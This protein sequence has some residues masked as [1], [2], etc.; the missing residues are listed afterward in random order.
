[1]SLLDIPSKIFLEHFVGTVNEGV[2]LCQQEKD[3]TGEEK[4]EKC[5]QF[6]KD[7]YNT[8]DIVL[9]IPSFIDD[10]VL[11]LAPILIDQA[12]RLFNEKGWE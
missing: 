2:Q 6:I 3:L 11:N 12:V 4:K 9:D 8:V 10:L 1:M 7:A 5:I